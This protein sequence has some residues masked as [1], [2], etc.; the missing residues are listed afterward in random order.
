[1]WSISYQSNIR[2]LLPQVIILVSYKTALLSF[3]MHPSNVCFAWTVGSLIS[4]VKTGVS[5]SHNDMQMMLRSLIQIVWQEQH[6]WEMCS[7]IIDQTRGGG[8]GGA[9]VPNITKQDLFCLH[10]YFIKY[11]IIKLWS[12]WIFTKKITSIVGTF[13]FYCFD[14]ICYVALHS[15]YIKCLCKTLKHKSNMIV[16]YCFVDF[17]LSMQYLPR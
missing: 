12:I 17:Y 8:G 7:K 2:S 16:F 1:M 6:F 4:Q 9:I 13:M 3:L 11:D 10:P 5:V 15:Q 14:N